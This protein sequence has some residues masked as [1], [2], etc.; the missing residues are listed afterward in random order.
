MK[1]KINE[2]LP[3]GYSEK[4]NDFHL[5]SVVERK[6]EQKKILKTDFIFK[7]KNFSSK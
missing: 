1:V 7:F 3:Q 5:H 6:R 4:Y 2:S